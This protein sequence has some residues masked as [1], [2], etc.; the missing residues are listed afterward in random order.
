MAKRMYLNTSILIKAVRPS[1]PRHGDALEF[2]RACCGVYECVVS[3]V[4]RLEPWKEATRSRVGS[5][6]RELG[7]RLVEVDV[8]S[9][10]AEAEEYRARHGLNIKRVMDIAHLVAARRLGCRAIA[11]VDRFIWRHAKY[12]GLLY[13][14]YYTGCQDP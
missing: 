14:N 8:A 12:F 2:L 4:H 11:A 10:L 3:S 7:A 5:L 13:L 1:D 6:L 9:V